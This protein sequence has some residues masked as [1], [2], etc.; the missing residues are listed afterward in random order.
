LHPPTFNSSLPKGLQVLAPYF[1]T[2]I[3]QELPKYISQ[4]QKGGLT[5]ETTLNPQWQ[6]VAEKAVKDTVAAMAGGEL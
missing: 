3:Q 4:K 5:V 1:T 2:Y 6:Q